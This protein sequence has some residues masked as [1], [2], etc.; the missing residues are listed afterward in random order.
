MARG[1]DSLYIGGFAPK[2]LAKRINDCQPKVILTATC[3]IEP[4]R[5]I[6]YIRNMPPF[7]LSLSLKVCPSYPSLA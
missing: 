3:G 1:T 5:I 6:P 2:E 4:K 7:S